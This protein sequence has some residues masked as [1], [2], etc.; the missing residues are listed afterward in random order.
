MKNMK[1]IQVMLPRTKL[2]QEKKKE[3]KAVLGKRC[4]NADK[5]P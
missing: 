2:L 5:N 3:I 1:I 4:E